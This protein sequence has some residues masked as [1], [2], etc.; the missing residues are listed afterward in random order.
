MKNYR[1]LAILLVLC[2]LTS[3]TA[4]MPSNPNQTE[5]ENPSIT[6]VP[7][8]SV[9]PTTTVP[10]SKTLHIKDY[11]TGIDTSKIDD[12]TIITL[13]RQAEAILQEYEVVIIEDNSEVMHLARSGFIFFNR[14]A[15]TWDFKA[16][17][18]GDPVG[19]VTIH[20][21]AIPEDQHEDVLYLVMVALLLQEY[22]DCYFNEQHDYYYRP[23]NDKYT[24][25]IYICPSF[26]GSGYGTMEDFCDAVRDGEYIIEET[27]AYLVYGAITVL[28]PL[29]T[30]QAHAL[31]QYDQRQHYSNLLAKAFPEA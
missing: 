11:V 3:L 19:L 4:C 23:S 30:A 1:L 25:P 16:L 9:T 22:Q 15:V 29:W 28:Y 10:G 6:T 8:T 18:P 31:D 12:D 20:T 2:I 26:I 21:S 13:L 17:K 27:G 7:T 14:D 5:P 24:G